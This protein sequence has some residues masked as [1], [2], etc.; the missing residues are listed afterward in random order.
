ML[1]TKNKFFSVALERFVCV[2]FLHTPTSVFA[3]C[4]YSYRGNHGSSDS[5]A[6]SLQ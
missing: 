3:G 6:F 1:G 5:G 2:S 4:W